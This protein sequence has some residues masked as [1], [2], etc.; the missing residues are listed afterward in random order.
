MVRTKRELAE[1]FIN[2]PSEDA[3]ERLVDPDHYW[4]SRARSVPHWLETYV[5]D[6]QAADEVASAFQTAI[7]DN[8]P[9]VTVEM[10]GFGWPTATEILRAL[11]PERFAILNNRSNEGMDALGYN[12]PN[13]KTASHDQ[14]EGFV[15]AVNEAYRQY[16]LR[17]VVEET[18]NE[19]IPGW[20]S[21][22]EI[23]DR[24]FNDHVEGRINLAAREPKPDTASQ[25]IDD[26]MRN[27]IEEVIEEDPTYRDAEDFVYA[28]IRAELER[29]RS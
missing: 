6:K 24:A 5:F 14:Y 23:A 12:P 4:A 26:E 3:F 11:E 27:V 28:A 22:L 1:D 7:E 25:I 9:R 13:P 10:D 16:N 8:T 20:A 21:H 29:A 19:P 18:T 17:D 2:N 15:D